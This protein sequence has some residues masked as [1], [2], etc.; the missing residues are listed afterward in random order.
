MAESA[1]SR[2][3]GMVLRALASTSQR[4]FDAV[5]EG[6]EELNQPNRVT[7]WLY[8][9]ESWFARGIAEVVRDASSMAAAS[10]YKYLVASQYVCVMLGLQMTPHPN[11]PLIRS[12]PWDA[13]PVDFMRAV[14]LFSRLDQQWCLTLRREAI[15]GEHLYEKLLYPMSLTGPTPRPMARR[16]KHLLTT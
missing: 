11:L 6:F 12:C 8:R 10:A 9:A 7:S 3:T 4:K 15:E 5:Y 14:P 13:T 2:D 1:Y 16:R